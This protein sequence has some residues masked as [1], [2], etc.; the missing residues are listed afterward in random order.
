VD[1]RPDLRDVFEPMVEAL[2]EPHADESAVPTWALS[3]AVGSAYKVALSGIGGDELFAGYRRHSGLLWAERYGRRIRAN[4]CRPPRI[5]ALC[6]P[7]FGAAS[8]Q[9]RFA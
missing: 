3:A 7:T 5:A 2:D 8:I 1:V 4:A 6:E 9:H